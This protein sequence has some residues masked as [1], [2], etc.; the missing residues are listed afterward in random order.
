MKRVEK[1]TSRQ[2]KLHA[3]LLALPERIHRAG[4]GLERDRDE[5]HPPGFKF[6]SRGFKV[7]KLPSAGPSK[8]NEDMDDPG[9][10]CKKFPGQDFA[11][12]E[13][14]DAEV[15]RQWRSRPFDI[16]AGTARHG[17]NQQERC[18]RTQSEHDL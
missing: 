1:Y 11:G 4:S 16:A 2:R 12:R 7:G 13:I 3:T 10:P 18:E 17:G 5:A 14:F 15:G 6:A 8:G 9:L